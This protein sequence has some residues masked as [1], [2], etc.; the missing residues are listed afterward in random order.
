MKAAAKTGRL[1]LGFTDAEV[2]AALAA[3]RLVPTAASPLQTLVL[4]AG[5][6]NPALAA[7]RSALAA[8]GL[9]PEG[10]L[11]W[12]LA[13]ALKAL[14]EPDE[15]YVLTERGPVGT[16]YRR[17]WG[18]RGLFVEHAEAPGAHAL[19][20]PWTRAGIAAEAARTIGLDVPGRD[21]A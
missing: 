10:R 16:R 14:S 20:F 7:G 1:G 18:R 3:A 4:S 12:P 8:R 2:W 5:L 21:A 17:F 19:G 9:A 11:N 13:A 6:L 15:S